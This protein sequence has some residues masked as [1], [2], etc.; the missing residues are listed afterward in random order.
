MPVTRYRRVEDMPRPWR[1]PDDPENL[2][3]V[4][5]ML[6]FYRSLMRTGAR[7]PGV[8]KFRS[9]MDAAAKGR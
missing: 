1:S 8:Q 7:R 3:V 5:Q 6:T 2:R 4:A 9:F